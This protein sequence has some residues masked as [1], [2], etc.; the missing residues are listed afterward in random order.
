MTILVRP[1]LAASCAVPALDELPQLINILRG[2][3]SLVGPRPLLLEEV[4]HHRAE[5]PSLQ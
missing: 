5:P 4:P 1:N 2:E 3:M